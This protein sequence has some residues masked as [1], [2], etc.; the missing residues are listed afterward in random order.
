MP[1]NNAFKKAVRA[2]MAT[3]GENYT[4]ARRAMINQEVRA[5]AVTEVEPVLHDG[6]ETVLDRF[7]EALLIRLNS[8]QALAVIPV[9]TVLQDA[10]RTPTQQCVQLYALLERGYRVWCGEAI[11]LTGRTAMHQ[12][13]LS[14]GRVLD[15]DSA[16][17]NGGML[18]EYRQRIE[19][20]PMSSHLPEAD[21]EAADQADADA[22]GVLLALQKATEIAKPYDYRT[23]FDIPQRDLLRGAEWCAK[24]LAAAA[25]ADI[26]VDLASEVDETVRAMTGR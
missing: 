2:R 21:H 3:T 22:R 12:G 8:D 10:G 17:Y 19:N 20:D 11:R 14:V 9:V 25:E 16:V 13:L 1:E 26:I 4:T 15:A 18:S 5:G 23:G 6:A 24:A 7:R